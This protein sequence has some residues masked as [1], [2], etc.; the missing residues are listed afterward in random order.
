[1]TYL[2]SLN[3]NTSQLTIEF[4]QSLDLVESAYKLILVD[5]QSTSEDFEHLKEYVENHDRGFY[6]AENVEN[7]TFD[8]QTTILLIRESVN[9]GYSAGNNHGIRI[10][11]NQNDFE[12]AV[13]IN[14][15]T[16]VEPDFLDEVLNFRRTN[17]SADL[18]GCRI[19]YHSSENIL[20]YDGGQYYKHT[21]RAIHINENKDVRRVKSSMVPQ[22]TT[23]ITGCFMYISK[24]C[25]D[26]C[27]LL[28]ERFFMYNE[29]LEYCIRAKKKGLSLY[30]VPSAI[31]R[32]KINHTSS[33]FSTYWGAKNRFLLSKLHSSLFDQ[34]ITVLFYLATR[35][36]VYS[37]WLC[38]GRKDLVKAQIKGM[39]DGLKEMT[40]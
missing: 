34:V 9:L 36:I 28:D 24:H 29:D 18:I 2:I 8:G 25:L 7:Y 23:F 27:G 6:L 1:M 26:V 22:K 16:E 30:Y 37:K 39:L 12:A 17:A 38:K 33:A 31:I 15:D 14:N 35:I 21:T 11:Q 20:W 5:N 13:L 32:H 19:F 40:I 4:L 10:A 3:Y